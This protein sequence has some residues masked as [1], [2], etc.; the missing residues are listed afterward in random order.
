MKT[1]N[2]YQL[3]IKAIISEV[4]RNNTAI[5]THLTES[6]KLQLNIQTVRDVKNGRYLREF[7]L[8]ITRTKG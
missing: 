2:K 8:V 1:L 4:F 3:N 6:T 7:K 5:N